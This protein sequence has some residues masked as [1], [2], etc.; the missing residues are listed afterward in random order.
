[1]PTKPVIY[2]DP[3]LEQLRQ[4][5]AGARAQL[6]ELEVDF[7]KE[8]SRVDVMQAVLFRQLREHYQRRDRLRL[9]VDYRRKFLD[10][11]VRGGE[12]EAKQAETHYDWKSKPAN[13]PRKSRS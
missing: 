9:I 5:V 7:T 2:V 3:E 8:K 10:S 12:E 6:A 11:L 1:M 13:S 4:L